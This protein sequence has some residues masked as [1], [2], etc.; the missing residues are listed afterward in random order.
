MADHHAFDKSR[1]SRRKKFFTSNRDKEEKHYGARRL[2]IILTKPESEREGRVNKGKLLDGQE[3]P[4][5]QPTIILRTREG[6]NRALS[7][8]QRSLP[9][10]R[11]KKDTE[12]QPPSYQ[13]AAKPSNP[14]SSNPLALPP[15]MKSS[16]KL[17]DEYFQISDNCL[18]FLTDQTDFL[19]IGCLGLQSVGK[20]TLM[21]HLAGGPSSSFFKT[22][23]LDEQETGKNCTVGVDMVVTTNR[24]ILLDSQPMLSAAIMEKNFQPESSRKSSQP[25]SLEFSSIENAME[26]QSLQ[27]AAFLLSVCHV[28]LLVQDWFFDPNLVRFIQ[29]AEMLKPPTPTTSQD[30]ELVEYFPHVMF[31]HTYANS[32][33]FS[34]DRVK[35]MQD[36]YS[37]MFARSRLQIQSGLGIANGGVLQLLSPTVLDQVPLNLFLLPDHNEE[38]EEGHF[39]GHP[40]YDKLL[41]K[42][43]QQIHGIPVN[44][45]THTSLTEKNWFHYS[46]KIWDGIK[47]S[48]FFHEY[49][50]LLPSSYQ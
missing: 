40:G 5:S 44:P 9:T 27:I 49:G 43:R 37:Q 10:S 29:T 18:E 14:E 34:S 1:D 15:E 19:V 3:K 7:P 6:D 2:P 38:K 8:S 26:V 36:V 13:L 41:Q 21:S 46:L 33:D 23:T 12:S 47:K 31:V 30:E 11:Q 48:N 4:L 39:K 22:Q 28:V 45:L 42:L 24:V 32:T 20:S 16:V 25:G 35:L 17:I 50:R